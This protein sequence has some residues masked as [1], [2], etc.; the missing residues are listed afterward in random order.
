MMAGWQ[1][2]IVRWPRSREGPQL[3]A[4]LGALLTF[5]SST[6]R[7]IAAAAAVVVGALLVAL[8]PAMARVA[9][10]VRRGARRAQRDERSEKKRRERERA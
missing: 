4:L 7:V 10:T 3:G 5:R 2:G 6:M 8:P 1:P 9:R